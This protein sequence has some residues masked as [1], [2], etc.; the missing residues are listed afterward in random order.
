LIL[1]LDT[2]ALVKLYAVEDGRDLTR[3]AI[4]RA[5]LVAS[6]LI[7]Y[8][9]TRSAFA[10]KHRMGQI[11]AGE[12]QSQHTEFEH[13]WLLMHRLAVDEATVHQAGAF[14]EEYRLKAYDALHLASADHLRAALGVAVTFAC[15]DVAL[16]AAAQTLGFPVLAVS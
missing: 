3:T 12:L 16:N 10:R 8:V 7:V 11:S 14:A 5:E 6:S 4:A 9:E 15:F 13:D 1:Y 2:S